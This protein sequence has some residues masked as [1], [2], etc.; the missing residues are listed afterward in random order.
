MSS[1]ILIWKDKCQKW[2][3]IDICH[4]L[5]F[6]P[7]IGSQRIYQKRQKRHPLA[8]TI[9]QLRRLV[10]GPFVSTLELSDRTCNYGK[11]LKHF[12][13][14]LYIV[15]GQPN[16]PNSM[17]WPKMSKIHFHQ[18]LMSRNFFGGKCVENAKKNVEFRPKT[19]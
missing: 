18:Q 15:S 19:A 13:L 5:I 17:E 16:K 14:S 2:D 11:M 7:A 9:N 4:P 12:V 6:S 3:D 10:K 8:I 1:Q